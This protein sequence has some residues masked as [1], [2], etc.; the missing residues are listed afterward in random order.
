M[1]GTQKLRKIHLAPL[2]TYDKDV[3]SSALPAKHFFRACGLW[4]EG[5]SLGLWAFGLR[6]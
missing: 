5:L 4:L 3:I 6:A 2:Q 1:E